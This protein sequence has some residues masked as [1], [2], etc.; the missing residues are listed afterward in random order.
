M[1]VQQQQAASSSKQQHTSPFALC[2]TRFLQSHVKDDMCTLFK[3]DMCTLFKDDMCTL[4][5]SSAARAFWGKAAC[6][7]G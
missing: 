5:A 4:G 3:D 7:F 1:Y 6:V 2:N